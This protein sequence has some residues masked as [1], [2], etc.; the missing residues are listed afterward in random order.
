MP[1]LGHRPL[2]MRRAS[3][4]GDGL[5]YRRPRHQASRATSNARRRFSLLLLK[6]LFSQRGND[7]RALATAMR[8]GQPRDRCMRGRYCDILTP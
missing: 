7:R 3:S 2:N 8:G 4:F 5:I 1:G 6:H